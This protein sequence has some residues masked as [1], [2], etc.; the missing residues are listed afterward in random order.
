MKQLMLF[1]ALHYQ[2]NGVEI[3]LDEF[4]IIQMMMMQTNKQY[5]SVTNTI[6]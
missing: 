2:T 5:K 6:L 3:G 1:D 4:S